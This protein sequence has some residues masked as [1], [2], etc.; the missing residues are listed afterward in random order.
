MD[1]GAVFVATC[2]AAAIGTLIMGLWARYPIAQAPGMGLNAFFAFTVVLGMGVPWQTA[3]AGDVRLGRAVLRARRD[4]CAGGDH[5][6]DPAAAQARGRRRHRPVHRVH[7][8]RTPGSSSRPYEA[9]FVTL[10][11]LTAPTTLLAIFGCWSPR[12]SCCAACA[13]ACST[14]SSS[15]RSPA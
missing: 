15:P 10:G 5:Q 1:F 4:R 2:L 14:A 6:R 8:A 3:L 13:A 11:D 9:T 12:C 7:R